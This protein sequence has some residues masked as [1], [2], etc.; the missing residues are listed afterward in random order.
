[1]RTVSETTMMGLRRTWARTRTWTSSRDSY[2]GF[3]SPVSSSDTVDSRDL[4]LGAKA[5]LLLMFVLGSG[6]ASRRT[7]D[8]SSDHSASVSARPDWKF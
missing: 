4:R 5:G 2:K 3:V 8:H 1:M 7:E 6:E